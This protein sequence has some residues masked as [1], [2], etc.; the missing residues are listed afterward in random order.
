MLR[1]ECD[2]AQLAFVVAA[3]EDDR[4]G[5]HPLGGRFLLISCRSSSTI[6][7][8]ALPDPQVGDLL[9]ALSTD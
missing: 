8:R 3:T 5:A 2:P 6:H 4:P 7:A 1:A 9:Q